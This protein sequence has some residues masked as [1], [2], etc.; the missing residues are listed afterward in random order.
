MLRP[1]YALNSFAQIAPED[2]AAWLELRAQWNIRPDTTYL[3]HGS[4]GPP[5]R[6]VR[7]ARAA[8]QTRL[9]EQPMDFLVRQYEPAYFAAR[10]QLARFVGAAEENLVFAENATSA[11]NHVAASFALSPGDE[12]LLT[13]HEYGAVLRI[14][15]RAAGRVGAKV[16]VARLP[17]PLRTAGDVVAAL[18]SALTS[19]T[20]LLVVSHITSPTEVT[21][22][23][24][25]IVVALK[26]RGVAVCIDGP[27]AVAQLPLALDELDCDYYCASCH[28]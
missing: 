9:D 12:V 20:K 6:A 19:R 15:E 2:D 24:R 26:Q 5:P 21:L 17:R 23:V 22:P 4:F 25:E 27:H 8:W 3:N 18:E 28:K 1:T 16:H 11:M 13:N 10:A 14:W 7:A